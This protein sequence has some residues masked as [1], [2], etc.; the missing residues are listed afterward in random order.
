MKL[1]VYAFIFLFVAVMSAP[2]FAQ[3]SDADT[4]LIEQTPA[5]E[6]G[7]TA[8]D[9]DAMAE[10]DSQTPDTDT[11]GQQEQNPHAPARGTKTAK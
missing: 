11:A 9:A 3:K 6:D 7:W 5:D 4:Q 10:L 2:V 1:F 8:E